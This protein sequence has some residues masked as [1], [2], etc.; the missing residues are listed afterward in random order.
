MG[1]LDFVNFRSWGPGRVDTFDPPKALLG[2]PMDKASKDE[3]LGVVDFPAVWN[4]K[5]RKGMQLHWDG[6]NCA[7][8]ERNLSAGFGTGATPAT[9]DPES[10]L[11]TAD[12]LW[13]QAKP[14][15]MPEAHID[16]T[17]ATRGE[18]I[19][20]E[21]CQTCHGTKDPP[22]RTAGDRSR[23]GLVTPLQQILTDPSR[24][25]GYTPELARAQNLLYAG[26]PSPETDACRDYAARLCDAN[27]SDDEYK[28]LRKQCFPA[29]FSHFRKTDGYAN[30]PLDGL[31]LRAPYLHNG[32]VPSIRAL[33]EPAS[34]RP[35]VFYTGYDVYD[36][37][38]MGFVTSGPDAEAHG[39]RYDTKLPGNHSSGHEGREYGTSLSDAD[40]RALIEYLKTF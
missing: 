19:Y 34:A 31:W 14:P 15:A 24:L 16:R 39:W 35:P 17:L 4:Q 28:A 36:F 33:L 13:D 38:A 8:D 12:F 10:V 26:K 18:S 37:A 5:A 3:T 2:F 29:R 1:Q 21:Y 32:S 23:V 27:Q 9:L 22:F 30:Q 25:D 7:V 11:R 40:K 6:N 20:R